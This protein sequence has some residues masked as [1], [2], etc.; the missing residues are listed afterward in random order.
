MRTFLLLMMMA[1]GAAALLYCRVNLGLSWDDMSTSIEGLLGKV[2]S[3]A[4]MLGA[5]AA[6]VAYI[7]PSGRSR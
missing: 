5:L 3:L 1:L 6:T 4:V 2:W 7:A